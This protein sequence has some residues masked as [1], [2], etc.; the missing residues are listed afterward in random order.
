MKYYSE[1]LRK[2]YESAEECAKA[3][4]DYFNKAEAEKKEKEQ[5]SAERK[6]RAKEVEDAYKA[7]ADAQR[8]YRKLRDAFCKDYGSFHMTFS[9]SDFEDIYEEF[10]RIF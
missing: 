10:F 1:V 8:N 3:E 7:V 5:R 4:K 9:N 2:F 6:A